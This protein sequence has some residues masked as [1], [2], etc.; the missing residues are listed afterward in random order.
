M[1]K[2]YQNA[3]RKECLVIKQKKLFVYSVKRD[4]KYQM[5]VRIVKYNLDTTFV[6]FVYFLIIIKIRIYF[7]VINVEFAELV[8]KK[9]LFIVINVIHVFL[10]KIIKVITV[11]IVKN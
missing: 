9:K 3:Q 6:K 5:S 2:Q 8:L 1:M 10:K 4:K 7:I 11:K